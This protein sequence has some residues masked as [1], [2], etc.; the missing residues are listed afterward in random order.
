MSLQY[1]ES[2]ICGEIADV[3]RMAAKRFRQERAQLDDL[4]LQVSL[5]SFF[6]WAVEVQNMRQ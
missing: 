4:S 5:E 1:E 3:G 6:S 2:M